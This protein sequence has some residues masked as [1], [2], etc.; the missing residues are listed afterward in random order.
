MSPDRSTA[1]TRWRKGASVAVS[2]PVP[3]PRSPTTQAGIQE[4][5]ECLKV[6]CPAEQLLPQLVP[7]GRSR[8]EELLGL[9]LPRVEDH[10]QP[11]AVLVRGPCRPNLVP[12]QRP[13][14]SR[15]VVAFV[16]RQRVVAARSVAPRR[17]PLGIG[18]SLEVPADGRLR[19]LQDGTQL[20]HR[21]LVLFEQEQ[22]SAAGRIGQRR[23]IIEDCRF[24]PYIR[25]KC[26]IKARPCQLPRN[27]P[28][29]ALV[30]AP[31]TGS[32]RIH[33]ASSFSTG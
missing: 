4:R 3:H 20:A 5:R 11:P 16:E 22:H 9:R 23:Q 31:S 2:S 33:T 24:H 32:R 15:L 21:Q 8:L 14:P 1:T 7:L 13:Q 30:S 6:R 27:W 26:Y 28:Y 25:I 19:E 17:H 18:Q 10:F 12:Q 29:L